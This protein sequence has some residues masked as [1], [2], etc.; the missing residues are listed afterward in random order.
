[1]APAGQLLCQPL[2]LS[3]L[4]LSL[5]LNPNSRTDLPRWPLTFLDHPFIHLHKLLEERCGVIRL[6]L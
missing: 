6:F 2:Q 4:S 5:N 3:A 1:M